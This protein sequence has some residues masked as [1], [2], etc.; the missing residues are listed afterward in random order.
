ME[1]LLTIIGDI[2][3]L[4]GLAVVLHYYA[5]AIAWGIAK[6]WSKVPHINT[7]TTEVNVNWKQKEV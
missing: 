4:I 6:G 3:A 2:F 1:H 5:M 7:G